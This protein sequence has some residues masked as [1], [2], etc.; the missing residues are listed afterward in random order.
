[1]SER[2]GLLS[3]GG[4]QPPRL[5]HQIN[6]VLS[7]ATKTVR[8]LACH[9]LN[10]TVEVGDSTRRFER[11]RHLAAPKRLEVSSHSSVRSFD[12]SLSFLT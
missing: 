3:G 9:H 7:S 10:R 12:L 8:D 11:L 2:N 5:V 4:M 6:H 1:M